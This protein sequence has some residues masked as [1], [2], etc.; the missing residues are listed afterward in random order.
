MNYR[1]IA[2]LQYEKGQ[3]IKATDVNDRMKEA[4]VHFNA[5]SQSD[6]LPLTTGQFRVF[7]P[8]IG[9]K[10]APF[11]TTDTKW[12][13][14]NAFGSGTTA[15]TFTCTSATDRFISVLGS[16][17]NPLSLL[18]IG[19]RY[20]VYFKIRNTSAKDGQ[21]SFFNSSTNATVIQS[22]NI[23]ANTEIERTF[24]FVATWPYFGVGGK[25]TGAGT[26]NVVF[27]INAPSAIDSS[28]A[29]IYIFDWEKNEWIIPNYCGFVAPSTSGVVNST[30]ERRENHA[31]LCQA[32]KKEVD[33]AQEIL[34]Y[35]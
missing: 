26:G 10:L 9:W 1:D 35:L 34:N 15:E 17:P 31:L 18:T 24:S 8:R 33:A 13:D 29:G 3:Q 22:F 11:F 28:V 20:Q 27:D 25:K 19:S 7:E 4:F 14:G 32:I 30:I 23:A 5:M 12:Y 2:K 21:L 16:T 6:V